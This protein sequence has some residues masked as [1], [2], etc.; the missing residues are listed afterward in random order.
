MKTI[1][2]LESLKALAEYGSYTEAA[3]RL[4][5]SQP[6]ITHH[7]QQ[8]E[9][10]YQATLLHRSGKR[11]QLTEQGEIVLN[12]ANQ[13]FELLQESAL[14]VKQSLHR[15]DGGAIEQTEYQNTDAAAE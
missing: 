7:I 5:C 4:Y 6:T 11:I 2:R 9:E 1:D 3:K 15:Q 13:M 8:L 10:Q 12:M 14:K